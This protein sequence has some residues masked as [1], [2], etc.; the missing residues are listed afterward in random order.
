MKAQMPAA[1]TIEPPNATAYDEIT[2]IF[3]PGLACFQNGSLSGLP[4][5]AMHSGVKLITGEVW[6]FVVV[7]NGVGANGQSTTLMPTGDGRFSITYTPSEYYGFPDGTVV[8]QICAVFNNGTNWNQ[9]GRDFIPG[10]PSCLDFF[11]PLNFQE[12]NPEIHFN[13]NMNKMISE[14]NFDPLA[15]LVYVEIDEV[16]TSLLADDNQDGIYKGIITEGIEVDSTYFYKFRI[17]NDHYENISRVITVLP[18]TLTIDVWWNNDPLPMFTFVVDMNFQAQ[19]GKFNQN[20]DFVDIAGTMNNWAGSSPMDSIGPNLFSITLN[21]E[22]GIVEYKFR[23]NGDWGT[24]ELPNGGPNRMTW[25]TPN[26]ITLNHFYDDYNPDAWPANFEVD[27]NAEIDAGNFNPLNDYLDI[28]GSMN[29][30]GGYSLLFDREW[31]DDGVYTI[32]ILI[33]KTNPD[34]AFKYRIN[35][36]W[37]T[38]EFPMGGPNRSWS[39]Q[40][41]TGG[42]INLFECVYNITNVPYAPYV[43]DL[44]IASDPLV[45]NEVSGEYTYFDA[46]ADPEGESL[47]QW[48][49]SDDPIGSTVDIIIGATFQNYSIT[50]DDFG[51]YL[52]FQ[53]TP[54]AASGDPS[55]GYPSAVI[56]GMVG[57][58]NVRELVNQSLQIYPNAATKILNMNSPV[59]I[60]KVEIFNLVGELIYSLNNIN[61][62][63]AI[64]SVA[65]LKVGIY[66]VRC[67]DYNG[68]MAT[69]K[70]AKN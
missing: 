13:L 18:A 11:I 57:Y 44:S 62:N 66:I 19:L 49:V 51:K 36:D 6:Q 24:S 58:T 60:T 14:G 53:V 8:T 31:T 10:T 12:N 33:D 5:I 34:I 28:A 67:F 20:T 52:I 39:V 30:W 55:I 16:G 38:S 21:L 59:E 2:L 54:V 48:F 69:A 63:K 37:A 29:N 42:L 50:Q 15:D 47:Y 32:K 1:I 7:F 43:Y 41:T 3:D 25:A 35:G 65:D 68:Q 70:F 46:N 23:I 26:P 56:S 17:N 4:S 40:D 45:G 61:S 27:M 64:I 9:D 22:P